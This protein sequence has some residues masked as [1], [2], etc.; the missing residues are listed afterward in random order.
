V[1]TTHEIFVCTTEVSS[2]NS[3][4]SGGGG[5]GGGGDGGGGVGSSSKPTK[6]AQCSL[7]YCD[8]KTLCRSVNRFNKYEAEVDTN[9][10]RDENYC[11]F[12][13]TLKTHFQ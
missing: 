7:T 13:L 11:H 3:S 5:G 8:Y 12:Y 2:R 6:V 4:S 9:E 10:L 1:K